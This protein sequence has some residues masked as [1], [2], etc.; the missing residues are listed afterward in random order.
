M[1][2]FSEEIELNVDKETDLIG[3]TQY[4]IN[5]KSGIKGY[6]NQEIVNQFYSREAE[7]EV[8][9]LLTKLPI[10][11]YWTTNYDKVIENGLKKN[12]RRGDIKKKNTRFIS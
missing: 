6:L 1:R 7:T 12:N 2:S 10:S 11:T 3:I 9:N 8:M 4:Y 5:S